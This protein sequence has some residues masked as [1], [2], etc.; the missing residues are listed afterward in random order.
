M[1]RI[2]EMKNK[3]WTY[4][5]ILF[6]TTHLVS[7]KPKENES[8]NKEQKG[9]NLFLYYKK[10]NWHYPIEIDTSAI[11]YDKGIETD[12][13]LTPVGLKQKIF[14]WCVSDNILAKHPNDQSIRIYDIDLSP[15]NKSKYKLTC[16]IDFYREGEIKD[17]AVPPVEGHGIVENKVL[18]QKEIAV[19]ILGHDTLTFLNWKQ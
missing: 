6:L 14:D 7:C 9:S 18:Q 11:C 2:I 13:K 3:K 10:N 19:L 4:L 1:V 5:L 12:N 8:P 16:R 15:V 17:G